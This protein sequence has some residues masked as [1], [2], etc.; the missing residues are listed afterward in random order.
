VPLRSDADED[1]EM[2]AD[3]VVEELLDDDDDEDEKELE[4][5]TI[6]E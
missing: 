4:G 2:M 6:G 3:V 1:R 5:S